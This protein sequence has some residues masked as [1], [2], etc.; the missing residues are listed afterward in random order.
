MG[1]TSLKDRILSRGDKSFLGLLHLSFYSQAALATAKQSFLECKEAI[2]HSVPFLM[3]EL[4]L[5][6][7]SCI[8]HLNTLLPER[9][10]QAPVISSGPDSSNPCLCLTSSL[11]WSFLPDLTHYLFFSSFLLS[12]SLLIW[13]FSTNFYLSNFFPLALSTVIGT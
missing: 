7:V 8:S 10:T 3:P 13:A 2:L 9:P 1:S 5:L 11:S 12:N 6:S 4:F